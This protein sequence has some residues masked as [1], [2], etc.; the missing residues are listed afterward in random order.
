[1]TQEEIQKWMQ[2]LRV[3]DKVARVYESSLLGNTYTIETVTKVTKTGQIKISNNEGKFKPQYDC[4]MNSKG[5]K[6]VPTTQKVL[7]SVE[8]ET[9]INELNKL[10]LKK[11]SVHKLREMFKIAKME[12]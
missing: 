10:E 5:R 8:K 11:L 7:D 2:E 3:G 4:G 12:E 1:M 6:I 9:L